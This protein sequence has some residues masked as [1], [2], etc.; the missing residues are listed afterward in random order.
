MGVHIAACMLVLVS[1]EQLRKLLT[2]SSC[3]ALMDMQ[4]LMLQQHL[5]CKQLL[6]WVY[7][8][9]QAVRDILGL[10]LGYMD[11]SNSCAE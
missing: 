2:P 4:V 6:A 3:S 10:V 1:C 8:P 9:F 7:K 5:F 11:A